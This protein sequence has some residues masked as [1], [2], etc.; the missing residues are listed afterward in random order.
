MRG[1]YMATHRAP[2]L[3]GQER[4]ALRELRR[5]FEVAR[6]R[7]TI[8][9]GDQLRISPG[10]ARDLNATNPHARITLGNVLWRELSC[11]FHLSE[12]QLT[13]RVPL[14][15][16]TLVDIACMTALNEIGRASC[17]ERV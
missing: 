8:T 16:V 4:Q 12:S 15:F 13:P 17:R 11:H 7:H 1:N 10:E 9:P 6:N 5:A 14:F 3:R 2:G